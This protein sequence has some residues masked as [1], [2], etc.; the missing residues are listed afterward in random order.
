M[1]KIP[2]NRLVIH[3]KRKLTLALVDKLVS[4]KIVSSFLTIL[5]KESPKRK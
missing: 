1:L 3:A 2:I 4:Q 5:G